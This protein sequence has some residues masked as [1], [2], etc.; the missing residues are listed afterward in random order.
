MATSYYVEDEF[1][2]EIVKLGELKDGEKLEVTR[3]LTKNQR[4]FLKNK[5]NKESLTKSLGGF[6]TMFYCNNKKL[7]EESCVSK[8]TIT[9]LMLLATYLDYNNNLVMEKND[10]NNNKI[11]ELEHDE[12][13]EKSDLQRVL[14]LKYD[15][16]RKFFI[17]AT[18]S[19]ILIQDGKNF[20]LNIDYFYKGELNNNIEKNYIRVYIS[21][22]RKIYDGMSPSKHNL[23]SYIF[24][25][26]PCI[27]YSTNYVCKN[28]SCSYNDIEYMN[29]CDICEFLNLST[30]RKAMSK[31][32]KQ[33]K[34]LLIEHNGIKY[35]LMNEVVYS[36]G[37]KSKQR[38]VINPLLVTSMSNHDE[39]K[40]MI[41]SLFI[42]E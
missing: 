3:D 40:E 10:D 14:G 9:R 6:I 7:Y 23:L 29:L 42:M 8:A 4:D 37:K 24:Q 21:T 27:H 30:D 31:F 38:F 20:K 11:N 34:S 18:K 13:M 25:L 33:I 32:K 35:Y 26:I 5:R 22:I 12:L 39:M 1:T 16:F 28:V 2:G 15:I 41:K 17:E 36:N 19:N